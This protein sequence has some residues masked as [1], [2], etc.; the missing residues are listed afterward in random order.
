MSDLNLNDA[1]TKYSSF[2]VIKVGCPYCIR[3]SNILKKRNIE[4]EELD[5][6]KY[7]ALNEE[8]TRKHG[9]KTCPKIF[10]NKRFIGGCE[11]LMKIN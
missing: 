1:L 2:M 10:L 9:I 7:P 3:A 5:R 8:I 11:D 4:F 6:T